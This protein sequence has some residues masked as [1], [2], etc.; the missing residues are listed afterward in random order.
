MINGDISLIKNIV[1]NILNQEC[2]PKLE[3]KTENTFV[4]RSKDRENYLKKITEEL[5]IHGWEHQPFGGTSSLGRLIL[6]S[7][8]SGLNKNLY[9]LFKPLKEDISAGERAGSS[10][11]QLENSIASSFNL[12]FNKFG[13]IASTGGFGHGSDL[14]IKNKK[15]PNRQLSVEVKTTLT[16]D[17]GQ[18]RIAYNIASNKWEPIQTSHFSKNKDIFQNIFDFVVAPYM[19]E[20]ASFDEL[21]NS[22]VLNKTNNSITG[23]VASFNTSDIKSILKNK[24]FGDRNDK[25]IEFD[26]DKINNYYVNKG[27][28]FIEIKDFGLFAL[29]RSLAN[30]F[31]I[32]YFGE[33]GLRGLIRIRIK[34]RAGP[35]GA[36]GFNVAIKIGGSL[37][38]SPVSL[39]NKEGQ[40]I[41]LKKA[42]GVF[43][44]SEEEQDLL[45][46]DVLG[47][48]MGN[49]S[50]PIP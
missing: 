38:R 15:H 35:N 36:H 11:K 41:I 21:I 8:K 18:F 20:N 6:S 17:F 22:N 48:V 32:P 24:W 29:T 40:N 46:A 30:Q 12:N 31:K 44:E 2:L 43:N 39:T 19:N 13:I 47:F 14:I 27:D 7:D 3:E 9:L 26:F 42:L 4:I 5:K 49:P 50:R 28:K 37:T 34:P 1:E 10:G 45:N 25:I 16:S 33:S 23:L